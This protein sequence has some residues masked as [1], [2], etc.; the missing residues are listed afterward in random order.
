MHIVFKKN[1]LWFS[2]LI[3][4]IGAGDVYVQTGFF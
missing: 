1:S 3:K 4:L 2:D